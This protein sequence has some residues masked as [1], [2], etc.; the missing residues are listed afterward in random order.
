MATSSIIKNFFISD[1]K[2]VEEFADA[3]EK[4]VNVHAS[5]LPVLGQQMTDPKEIKALMLKLK[6]KAANG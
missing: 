4:A 3:L 5:P 1:K 2:D 6:G